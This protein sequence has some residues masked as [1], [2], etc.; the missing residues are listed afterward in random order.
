M[1]V[2]LSW[3]GFIMIVAFKPSLL[4]VPV[5]HGAALTVGVPVGTAIIVL[6]WLL[7]GWYVVRANTEF[8]ALN[9]EI[10]TEARR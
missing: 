7:T 10:L 1:V 5:L 3:Y 2:W 8:D 4:R 6:G 9:Q